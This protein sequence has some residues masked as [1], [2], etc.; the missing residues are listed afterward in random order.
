RSELHQLI[1]QV[2]EAYDTYDVPGATRPVQAFVEVLS[3]WYVRLS[4][5]RFWKSESDTDKLSAYA[6]LYE[7]LVTVAKLIAPAAPFISEA[8][9]R[10]LAAEV[11]G[12]PPSVHLA[13]WPEADPSLIEQSRLDEVGLVQGVVSLGRAARD[14]GKIGARRPL[15][16]AAFV[17]REA[18]EAAILEKLPG[19]IRNELNVNAVRVLAEPQ[20]ALNPLPQLLGRKFGKNFPRVQKALREGAQDDVQRW[21]KM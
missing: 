12:A 10:N 1:Q 16:E 5:R 11:N 7:C 19:L 6:T 8:I 4:R 14:S 2:T 17:V 13:L 20:Y 21:A 9:Y 15:A 18:G 3:N